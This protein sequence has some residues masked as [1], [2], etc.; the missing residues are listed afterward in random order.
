MTLINNSVDSSGNKVFPQYDAAKALNDT[1]NEAFTWLSN[2]MQTRHSFNNDYCNLNKEQLERKLINIKENI[3]NLYTDCDSGQPDR[4]YKTHTAVNLNTN[5]PTCIQDNALLAYDTC[6]QAVQMSKIYS[7]GTEELFGLWT[8]V[9]NSIPGNLLG[10]SQEIYSQANSSCKKWVDMFNVW[11]KLEE[12]AI[13]VPCIPERPDQNANDAEYIRRTNEF[14][15][16]AL[17]RLEKLK[18]RL[19]IIQKYIKNYPHILH[20]RKEDV[21]L[22]P[23]TIP[24]TSTI[25][26]DVENSELGVAPMQYLEMILPNGKPGEIGDKGTCGIPGLNGP[27]GEIGQRG[28]T[29]NPQ[30]P[31]K[32]S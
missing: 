18:E 17:A 7:Y 26:Y 5:I 23:Y 31:K 16:A 6:N 27:I 8:D 15:N 19:R 24:A 20:I 2:P 21:I 4:T 32:Y 29:G 9:S 30:L 22:G 13:S 1:I 10:T 11:A 3:L 28:K 14:Y 25:K 12:E